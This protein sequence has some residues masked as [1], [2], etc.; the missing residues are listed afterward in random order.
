MDT[1]AKYQTI[2]EI[3]RL[4]P[5]GKVCTYGIIAKYAGPGIT[6][7]LVGR[8]LTASHQL[9]DLPAHRVVNAQGKLTG[10]MHFES[11]ATMQKL[12]EREGITIKNDSVKD[13]AFHLWSPDCLL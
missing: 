12:L 4:I 9:S 7:R 6:A 13:F 10:K 2:Y 8:A 1:L 5:T 11:P 3:V